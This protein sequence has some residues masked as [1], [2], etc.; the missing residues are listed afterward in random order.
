MFAN[1]AENYLDQGYVVLPC[2]PGH[3]V[4]GKWDGKRWSFMNG[5]Q[6]TSRNFTRYCSKRSSAVANN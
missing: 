4:P 5:W 6:T 2:M 3:K 1:L